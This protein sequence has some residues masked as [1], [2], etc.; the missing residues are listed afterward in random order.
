MAE[1]KST[2]TTV[3]GVAAAVGMLAIAVAYF[4]DGD[5]STTADWSGAVQAI[6]AVLAAFGVSAG[7]L[8]ARDDDVSSEG[9][10]ATKKR[11]L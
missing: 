3:A 9:S 4:L 11:T 1:K 7:G 2:K 8:F 5:P 10:A 6:G